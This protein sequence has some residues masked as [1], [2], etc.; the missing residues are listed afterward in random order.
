MVDNETV[1]YSTLS[2][3]DKPFAGLLDTSISQGIVQS[4]QWLIY[5]RVENA[6]TAASVA[7]ELGGKVIG[8]IVDSPFG[9]V[10]VIEDTLGVRIK[11]IGPRSLD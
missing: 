9:R 3:G 8:P 4:S 2:H 7:V 6:N 5:F 10:G 1:R 11:I